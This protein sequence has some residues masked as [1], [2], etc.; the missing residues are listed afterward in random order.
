MRTLIAA[1]AFILLPVVAIASP[2]TVDFILPNPACAPVCGQTGAT[3]FSFI[4]DNGGISPYDGSFLLSDVI[5]VDMTGESALVLTI[6]ALSVVNDQVFFTVNSSGQ[7]LLTLDSP[8]SPGRGLILGDAFRFIYAP[9]SDEIWI[10]N[11]VAVRPGDAVSIASVHVGESCLVIPTCSFAL[12]GQVREVP[13]PASVSLLLFGFMAFAATRAVG[14]T[15][16]RN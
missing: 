2:F 8:Q 11:G 5:R 4:V 7:A 16:R 13:E 1:L 6:N 15:T 9:G 3:M 14:S 12:T 10:D